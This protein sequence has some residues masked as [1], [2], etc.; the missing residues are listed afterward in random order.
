MYRPK[1]CSECGARIIRV[2]WHLWHSRKFCG[3]C[4]P[5]FFKEQSLK[6]AA[7]CVFVLLTGIAIGHAARSTRAALVI[8]RSQESH[9]SASAATTPALNRINTPASLTEEVYTCGARTKKG[10]PCSRRVHGPV[11]CWQHKGMAAMLPQE[12]L[13]VKD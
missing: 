11:R 8:Q 4:A 12:K 6:V 13:R 10:T 2:R 3:F 7:A 1:F 5:R 9:L